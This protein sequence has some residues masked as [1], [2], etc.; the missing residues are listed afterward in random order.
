[1][2][3]EIGWLKNIKEDVHRFL[4]N[5]SKDNY[6]Y[7]QYSYSGD[8]P[9][10]S[11]GWGLANMVFA[12]KILYVTKLLDQTS[13]EQRQNL[14][15]GIIK[16]AD[17]RGYIYDPY[18]SKL[19]FKQRL[20][21]KLGVVDKRINRKIE[22]I[23]RAE[24]RQSFV[25]LFL[26]GKK[27]VRPFAGVPENKEAIEKYL[28]DLNWECP[29]AAASHFSHLLFFLK[30]NYIFFNDVKD[31]EE[32]ID[33]TFKW[34]CNIQS[35]KDGSWYIGK[36]VPLAQKINGALKVFTGLHAAGIEKI[37][38]VHQLIDTCLEGVNDDEACSNFNIAYVL[39]GCK[40][41][42]NQYRDSEIK[43]F[44]VNRLNLYKQYYHSEAGGFSFFK[45][46]ANTVYYGKQLTEGKNEPDIHGTNM[47]LTGIAVIDEVLNLGL[48]LQVP[49]N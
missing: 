36:N 39:Y 3:N 21:R 44:L 37:P 47:F 13:K 27:P 15:Q 48:D 6:E 41:V 34:I 20:K 2:N 33:Y 4:R 24:T 25:S 31:N 1:M 35:E 23:R 38:H 11:S 16:F 29:W 8:I 7:F 26:L 12:V 30:Y 49:I 5:I 46:K 19:G 43:D 45:N 17:E 10:R 22:E 14:F 40:K 9:E 18:I 42:D 32:L 28:S